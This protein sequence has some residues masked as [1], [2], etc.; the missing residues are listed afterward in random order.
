MGKFCNFQ[1]LCPEL[2]VHL[3]KH[4]Q[5]SGTSSGGGSSSVLA[6]GLILCSSVFILR[7]EDFAIHQVGGHPVSHPSLLELLAL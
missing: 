7:R 6:I 4:L 5:L 1:G 3:S 2:S